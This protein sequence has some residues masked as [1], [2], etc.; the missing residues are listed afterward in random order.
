MKKGLLSVAIM[1]VFSVFW[2]GAY[3]HEGGLV[4]HDGSAHSFAL[5]PLDIQDVKSTADNFDGLGGADIPLPSKPDNDGKT[6]DSKPLVA[7]HGFEERSFRD[8]EQK[9]YGS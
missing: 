8:V 9:D 6:I 3:A 7:V 4:D 1:L 2:G 5:T